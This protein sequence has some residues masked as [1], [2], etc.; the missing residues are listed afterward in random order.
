VKL[1]VD[2]QRGNKAA[3]AVLRVGECFGEG[4][5]IAK[6]ICSYTATA[7]HTATVGRLSGRKLQAYLHEEPAFAKA[8]TAHLI[9]RI[10]RREQDL[11]D[12]LLNSSEQRLARLLLQLSDSGK[13]PLDVLIDQTTLAQAVGTTRSRVSY[14]MNEFRKKGYIDYNG[15]LQVHKSLVAFLHQE[16]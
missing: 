8:F 11:V 12:Q 5:L 13:T 2:D 16:S 15:N 3:I 6:S 10:E 4:C 7:V 9:R 14:F 1:T